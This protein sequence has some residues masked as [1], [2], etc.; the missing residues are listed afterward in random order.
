VSGFSLATPGLV[1]VTLFNSVR[2]S[3]RVGGGDTL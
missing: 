1:I 3:E 2:S